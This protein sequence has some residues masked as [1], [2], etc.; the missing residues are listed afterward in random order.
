MTSQRSAPPLIVVTVGSDSHPFD[1]L[2]DWVDDWVDERGGDVTLV[3][4]HGQA[5]PPRHGQARPFIPYEELQQLIADAAVVAC[6][7]GP[8]TIDECLRAGLRPITVPRSRRFGEA[9]DDHQVTF[10]QLL[11]RHQQA[12]LPESAGQLADMLDEALA[13]PGF[14]ATRHGSRHGVTDTVR[15]FDD[16]VR[17]VCPPA[18]PTRP[19]T[20]SKLMRSSPSWRRSRRARLAWAFGLHDGEARPLE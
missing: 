11:E 5:H 8:G 15:Q 12:W 13:R 17:G 4:Q 3:V 14:V 18:Q 1:R 16:V 20:F 19:G 2:I 9:V 6:H 10:T 7:G